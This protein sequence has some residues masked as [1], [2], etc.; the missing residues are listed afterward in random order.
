MKYEVYEALAVNIK[1]E[2]FDLDMR[3]TVWPVPGDEFD[4]G[5][6]LPKEVADKMDDDQIGK[7]YLNKFLFDY[8]N[9]FEYIVSRGETGLKHFNRKVNNNNSSTDNRKI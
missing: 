3:E 2:I 4:P 7:W 1:V 6:W 5:V 8:G 9:S